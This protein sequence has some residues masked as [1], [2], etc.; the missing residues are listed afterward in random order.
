MTILNTTYL[1]L[2]NLL[3]T[4]SVLIVLV[5]VAFLS[6]DN[7]K[8]VYLEVFKKSGIIGH[9]NR[10]GRLDGEFEVYLEGKI[11]VKANFKQGLRDGWCIWYYPN[12]NKQQEAFYKSGK[13]DGIQN[14]YYDNGEL[15]YTI[16][17]KNGRN[18]DS[19][20]HYLLDHSLNNYNA[21]DLRPAG[22]NCFLYAVYDKKRI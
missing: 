13:E 19:E 7:Y 3:I 11:N 16:K 14:V 22:D 8:R 17:S 6:L 12:G 21:F 9:Y 4:T 2:K 15:N 18:Y 1:T 20:Y 5:L 10:N